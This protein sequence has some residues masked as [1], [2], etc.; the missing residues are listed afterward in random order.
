M[1]GGCSFQ[2]LPY[3][4]LLFSLTCYLTIALR[5]FLQ[6]W[7]ERSR[8]K[9]HSVAIL[10]HRSAQ[11]PHS[12]QKKVKGHQKNISDKSWIQKDVLTREQKEYCDHT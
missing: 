6:I 7:H 9:F 10:L 3:V 12:K 1:T 11:Q 8:F 4:T 2:I 5:E